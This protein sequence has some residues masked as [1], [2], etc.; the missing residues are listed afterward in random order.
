MRRLPRQFLCMRRDGSGDEEMSAAGLQRLVRYHGNFFF[1][2]FLLTIF[3]K[4]ITINPQF[5]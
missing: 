2:I 5:G 1:K 4:Y 3:K